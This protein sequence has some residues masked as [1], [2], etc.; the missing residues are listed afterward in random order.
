MDDKQHIARKKD[1]G[2]RRRSKKLEKDNDTYV[3]T[4]THTRTHVNQEIDR[5]NYQNAN[6]FNI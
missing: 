2:G 3:H 6:K 5:R 4:Y 1:I